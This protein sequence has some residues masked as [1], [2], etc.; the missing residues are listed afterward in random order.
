MIF[1]NYRYMLARESFKIYDIYDL[2]GALFRNVYH[3]I[4]ELALYEILILAVRQFQVT[5]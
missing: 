5:Y 3:L 1:T 2:N 4:N